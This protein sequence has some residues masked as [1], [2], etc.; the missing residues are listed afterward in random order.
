MSFA[1]KES[2]EFLYRPITDASIRSSV[3]MS[4]KMYVPKSF[5]DKPKLIYIT[6]NNGHYRISYFWLDSSLGYVRLG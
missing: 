6:L 1:W 5:S 4:F 3:P 2:K